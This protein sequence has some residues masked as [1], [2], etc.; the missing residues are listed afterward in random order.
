MSFCWVVVGGVP[1]VA[2]GCARWCSLA[3]GGCTDRDARFGLGMGGS[4][5][6]VEDADAVRDVLREGGRGTQVETISSWPSRYR[7]DTLPIPL[8]P[9]HPIPPP[10]GPSRTWSI[11]CRMAA[12]SP[13]PSLC[14]HRRRRR[15]R[16]RRGQSYR[17]DGPCLGRSGRCLCMYAGAALRAEEAKIK[18]DPKRKAGCW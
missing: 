6:V 3:S 11:C 10:P 2:R 13:V 8:L 14:A 12:T 5:E 1:A 7:S 4:V 9:T 17:S 16:R 18:P 15:R